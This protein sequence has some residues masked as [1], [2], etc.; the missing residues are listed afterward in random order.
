LSTLS[1][2]IGARPIKLHERK[3]VLRP[4]NVEDIGKSYLTGINLPE[5]QRYLQTDRQ[6][7][8]TDLEDYVR[9]NNSRADSVLLGLFVDDRHCG[10]VRLHDYD[11]DQIWLGI[12]IF[13]PSF[14]G[15]G[16]GRAMLKAATSCA[17]ENLD[18]RKVLA[19]IDQR[20]DASKRLFAGCGFRETSRD[21]DGVIVELTADRM[22]SDR[23]DLL[24]L[25]IGTANFGMPYGIV[26]GSGQ[27]PAD[28]VDG[29]MWICAE[30]GLDS[31][32]TAIG[33]GDADQVLGQAALRCGIG[34]IRVTTKIPP[35][36]PGSS[37]EDL[38]DLLLASKERLG[39][40]R[41]DT[42]LLHR[43]SDLTE[44]RADQ[45]FDALAVLREKDITAKIGISAY[46]EDPIEAITERF[47]L[48]VIQIPFSIA[49]QRLRRNGLLEGLKQRGL[50][51]QA[52]S[53]LLQGVLAA[54]PASLPAYFCQVGPQLAALEKLAREAGLTKLGACLSFV[55]GE[56][57][58]DS[59]VIGVNSKDQLIEL[60]A[61]AKSS[62][63]L[64]GQTEACAWPDPQ[65]LH[66]GNWPAH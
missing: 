26:S 47:D 3:A 52:R 51:V 18:C 29:I 39:I 64:P 31:F 48:D 66:P 57:S 9:Q 37:L 8:K 46:A 41:F 4:L 6:L 7:T 49:D 59:V 35:L 36:A 33:Y 14:W 38:P 27:I 45:V 25:T 10:N 22:T 2:Q 54:D 12:A 11:G 42:V 44:G 30:Q 61:A 60:I 28:E 63:M 17:I 53:V 43:A 21:S 19:G 16:W 56:P 23:A 50:E 5:V 1:Q 15:K 62:P 40:G 58:I 55:L 34:S 32:D 13:D 24:P 20:N 65:M